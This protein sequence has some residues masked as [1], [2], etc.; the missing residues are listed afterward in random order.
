M[1]VTSVDVVNTETRARI[2]A[3]AKAMGYRLNHVARS[4]RTQRT[5]IVAPHR[6]GH[7]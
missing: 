5:S 7:R 1:L 6:A 2:A 4:L 3:M